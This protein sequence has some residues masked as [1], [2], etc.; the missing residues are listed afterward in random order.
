MSS[1]ISDTANAV[2]AA[3]DFS[4]FRCVVDVAGGQGVFL[5]S[6]LRANPTVQGILFD[7][8]QVVQSAAGVLQMDGVFERCEFIGGSFFESVPTGGDAY[9]L[10]RIIHDWEDGQAVKILKGCRRA[11]QIGHT[12]LIV[13]RVL[14]PMQPKLG[15][16]LM[17]IQMMVMNG[18]HERTR[19]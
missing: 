5:S 7:Q 11:M 19:S 16:A 14:D 8:V 3:Y 9:L 4:R 2:V 13:E 10:S 12:L 17:D 1:R 18:G 15:D 6:I